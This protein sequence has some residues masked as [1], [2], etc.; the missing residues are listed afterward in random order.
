MRRSI[1]RCSLLAL[2]LP[3]MLTAGTTSASAACRSGVHAFGKVQAR[4]FCGPASARITVGGTS[5]VIRGGECARTSSSFALNI[6]TVVLGDAARRPDYLGVTVV[7]V[8]GEPSV[9]HD[10]TYRRNNVVALV[11]KRAGYAIVEATV[12]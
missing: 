2:V 3:A 11:Y 5:I 1:R 10:G 12:T 4:T 7:A 9:D 6:G 8:K